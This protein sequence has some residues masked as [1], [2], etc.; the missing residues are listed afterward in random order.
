M[1]VTLSHTSLQA[2]LV[3][4]V[5]AA[6]S[7]TSDS[8]DG[9]PTAAS[10]SSGVSSTPSTTAV[11]SA[12]SSAQT[13]TTSVNSSTS[14]STSVS[15]STVAAS[16]HS[17]STLDSSESGTHGSADPTTE[18]TAQASST[19]QE[20]TAPLASDSTDSDASSHEDA[21]ADG[22]SAETTS[23]PPVNLEPCVESQTRNTASGSG[24]HQVVVETNSD[25]GINQGT[26]FRPS[27]LGDDEKYPIF[28][29]G[30]G[31][32]SQS[33]LESAN[34]MTEIASHGYFVVSDGTPNGS[35]SREMKTEDV[36]SMGTPLLAYLEWAVA[37]NAKPCSAYYQALDT[38][39]IASN[40]FSCGGLMAEGTSAD[41]RLTTWGVTS[42][43]M[44]T[45]S[46]ALY[47][48]IHPGAH[49][50]RWFQR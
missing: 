24:P 41:E 38:T 48:A 44:I 4:F 23:E 25:G 1:M 36:P 15:S 31:A 49:R 16:S 39:K 13:T 11:N 40:G 45:P 20:S 12:A 43:G 14:T 22:T 33:G 3:I 19:G 28:V 35:G 2:L 10:S 8:R 50:T 46:Q 47:D 26:I 21:G 7:P 6:C 32:C 42:S 34:A 17:E 18:S 29:W 37:E 9:N 5:F 27:D 30:Q